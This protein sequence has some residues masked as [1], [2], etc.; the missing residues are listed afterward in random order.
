MRILLIHN[1]LW[2]HYKS[3]LFSGIYADLSENCPGS[4]FLVV[5][6]ALHEASRSVMQD[7]Q[8][9]KYHY[10]NQVLFQRSLDTVRFG[11]RVKA[12]FKAFDEFKPTVLNVTG[13]FDYAQVLLMIYAKTKGVRVVLS[14][15][16][17]TMDHNR[18]AIKEKIKSWI[19]NRADAF[20]CFGTSSANYL[21]SLGIN[22]SQIAVRNAAVIDEDVIRTNFAQARIET[23]TTKSDAV[24]QQ[25]IYVGRLADEK[26]LELLIRA[27]LTI[28]ERSPQ[29][30]NWRLL[31]VGDGPAR[32]KLQ[33]LSGKYLEEQIIKFAGGFPWYKVPA[34][35]AQSDV[36]VLPS[37]SEPWGLVVNEAM[38]CGLP[39]IVSD[40]C[41]CAEDLVHNQV[42]GFSFNPDRQTELESAMQ[43]F[44]EH[45]DRIAVMGKESLKLIQPFSS[46]NVAREMVACYKNLSGQ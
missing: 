7:D 33:E 6:I 8:T 18:S 34:W 22:S 5:H 25:F 26:N 31:F 15:E 44:I 21:L 43:F 37:K 16:S 10:P 29:A 14:S 23:G 40:K 35:L 12:L 39:V 38:V 27:F 36:L 42:N 24:H 28:R 13:Y 41:G 20:F 46:K 9:V 45:P 17:S 32:A 3:K 30:K 19:V 4:D 11:E 2:A 1:Q